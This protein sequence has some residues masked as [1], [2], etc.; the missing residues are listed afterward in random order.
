[1]R[2][3]I[4]WLYPTFKRKLTWRSLT[5]LKWFVFG[6]SHLTRFFA[7]TYILKIILI[8]VKQLNLLATL[9][10]SANIFLFWGWLRT[11]EFLY[12]SRWM[13]ITVWWNILYASFSLNLSDFSPDIFFNLFLILE[14][15]S[16][17]LIINT[18]LIL[19]VLFLQYLFFL[20]NQPWHLL[21]HYELRT[22][23]RVIRQT[24]LSIEGVIIFVTWFD[25]SIEFLHLVL[26]ITAL[27]RSRSFRFFVLL[28]KVFDIFFSIV[29][30]FN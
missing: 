20:A 6:I 8:W 5:I 1:M 19:I 3:V 22:E 27:A 14:S 2:R 24:K 12:F 9:I 17:S 25:L 26:E 16:F 4:F 18:F 10:V 21:L 13:V 15:S 11:F 30:L 7:W 28:L 29:T 23:I